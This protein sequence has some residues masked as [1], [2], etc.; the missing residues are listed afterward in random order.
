M[1]RSIFF[2]LYRSNLD[3]D[4]K[5][6]QDEVDSI[7]IVLNTYEK[8]ETFSLN[9]WAYILATIFHETNG[10]FKPIKEA[11]WLSE[12]W[13]KNNLRYYPYYG[14]DYV[15][16]TWEENFR[17]FSKLVGVDLVKYPEK[18]SEVDIALFILLHGF[19]NGT[20]TGRGISR[21]INNKKSDYRNARRCI[22]GLDKCDLIAAYAI[23]FQCILKQAR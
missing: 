1:D 17:K 18:I 2:N 12:N 14:R 19:K 4:H 6:T 7:N 15:H 5:L 20:W 10:C 21:Y 8:D 9:Q 22:N 23:E 16:T 3:K 11:Y 13:R